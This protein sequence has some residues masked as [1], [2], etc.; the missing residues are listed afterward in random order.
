MKSL[1]IFAPLLALSALLLSAGCGGGT[2]DSPDVAAEPPAPEQTLS[3]EALQAT[4]AAADLD[5]GTAD[6]VVANC[7]GCGLAMPGN[8]EHAF[9][10]E[11][12]EL[13][14]CS[15]SCKG[16]FTEDVTAGL[17]ALDLSSAETD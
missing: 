2:A 10:L 7:P 9:E 3:P 1:T 16:R 8:A 13:H 4:L 11:G 14:F 12:Y 15:E 17:L 5:D 6:H